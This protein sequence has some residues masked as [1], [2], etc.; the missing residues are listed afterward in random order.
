MLDMVYRRGLRHSAVFA[1]LLAQIP[2]PPQNLRALVL[3]PSAFIIPAHF[4][5]SQNSGQDKRQRFRAALVK[6]DKVLERR[7]LHEQP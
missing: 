5:H 7:S 4:Y 6:K 1:A 2:V 3:P